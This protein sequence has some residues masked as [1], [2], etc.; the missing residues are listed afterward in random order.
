M[1]EST[2]KGRVDDFEKGVKE[3]QSFNLIKSLIFDITF[4][5]DF[6][7]WIFNFF[8]RKNIFFLMKIVFLFSD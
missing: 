3:F 1:T 5:M 8:Q 4:E 2:F 6:N 7:Y